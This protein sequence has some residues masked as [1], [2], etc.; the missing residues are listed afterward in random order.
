MNVL[1]T[2]PNPDISATIPDWSREQCRRWW[3]PSRRLVQ[4]L[5][6]Y[7]R[8]NEPGAMLRWVRKPWVLVYR[9]WSIVCGTE[10]PL[11]CRIGGGLLMPHPNGI[12]LFPTVVIGPNCLIF[13]QV[14]IGT[15]GRP[16]VPTLGGHVEVGAGA[17]ILGGIRIGNHAR[18]GAN[19]V[20]LQD[21][22]DGATAV[23]IPARI[24]LANDRGLPLCAP[25]DTVEANGAGRT[26]RS[27]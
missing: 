9:F 11:N 15:G 1:L 21:V 17:K 3:D 2:E 10:I 20:V 24:I 22:P 7:Q 16:G 26:G 12:V 18:V 19:A 4:A 27:V 14:T 6:Q 5:R 8:W 13:Q 23:G 25:D